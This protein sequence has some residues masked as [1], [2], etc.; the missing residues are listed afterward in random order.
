MA[1]N[2]DDFSDEELE[3]SEELAKWIV[4]FFKARNIP[5]QQGMR[6]LNLTTVGLIEAINRSNRK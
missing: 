6:L 3:T 5:H 4:S 1:I 2:V